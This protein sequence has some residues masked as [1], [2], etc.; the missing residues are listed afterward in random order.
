MRRPGDDADLELF[1]KQLRNTDAS[2]CEPNLREMMGNVVCFAVSY[3]HTK[4]PVGSFK[5]TAMQWDNFKVAC[6][7]I[8][9]CGV[10]KMRVRLDSCLWLRDVSQGVWADTC[11]MPYVLWPV[12]D[13]GVK[14]AGGEMALE[15]FQ[16][17]RSFIEEIDG[18][19]RHE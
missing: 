14:A 9:K 16:R 1:A 3:V 17:M 11:L 13:L 6:P 7:E 15:A 2:A 5:F 4:E 12:I 19:N 8:S 10:E 18:C